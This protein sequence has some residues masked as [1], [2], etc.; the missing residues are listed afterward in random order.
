M[1]LPQSYK[2]DCQEYDRRRSV[3]WGAPASGKQECHL[4]KIIQ[5]NTKR[6]RQLIYDVIVNIETLDVPW[7]EI[8][9]RKHGKWLFLG[10]A[11]Q[12]CHRIIDDEEVKEKHRYVCKRINTLRKQVGE[13]DE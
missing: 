6:E 11:C 8:Y 5:L 12:E 3:E 13:E 9:Q 7:H 4:H 10:W 2:N 1:A